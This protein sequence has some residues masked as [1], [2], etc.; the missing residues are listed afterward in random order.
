MR[1]VLDPNDDDRMP[2]DADPLPAETIAQLR[3]L[4]R[5]GRADACRQRG[6]GGD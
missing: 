4:D 6:G 3:E 1:R 2:L 5:S